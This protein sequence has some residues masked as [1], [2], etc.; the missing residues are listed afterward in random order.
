MWFYAQNTPANKQYSLSTT[1]ATE[2]R[3]EYVES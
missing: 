3:V 2:M 1:E